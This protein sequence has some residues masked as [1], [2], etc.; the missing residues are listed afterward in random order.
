MYVAIRRYDGIEPGAVAEFVRRVTADSG[1]A[2][3][4]VEQELDRWAGRAP[5]PVE[6][7]GRGSRRSYCAA[8]AGVRAARE[9]TLH[10][11]PPSARAGAPTVLRHSP[12][13]V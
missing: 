12:P 7:A 9:R 3:P 5:A 13:T 10:E 6:R 4:A 8:S 2:T 11:Q 1:A